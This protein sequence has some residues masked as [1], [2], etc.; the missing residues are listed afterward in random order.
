MLYYPNDKIQHAGVILGLDGVAGHQLVGYSRGDRGYFGRAM[1][2][3]D[4]SC[5]TAACMGMRRELF[6]QL[7]G[8][9]EKLLHSTTSISVFGSSRPG[10]GLSGHRPWNIIITSRLHLVGIIPQNEHHN[11]NVK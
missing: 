2:E 7:G 5:V 11:L 9:D 6:D 10:G 3:Q 1:L 8:F 4:L